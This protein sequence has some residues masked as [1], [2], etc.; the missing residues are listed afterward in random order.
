MT[1]YAAKVCHGCSVAYTP[2]G[3]T[4]K[5]CVPTCRPK[6]IATGCDRKSTVGGGS[7]CAKCSAQ[8]FRDSPEGKEYFQSPYVKEQNYYRWILREFGLTREQYDCMLAAQGFKCA[9]VFCPNTEDLVVDH[10]HTSGVVR[11]ILCRQCNAALG[12]LGDSKSSIM[13]VLEYLSKEGGA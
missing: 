13:L 1:R 3:T 9:L 4:Q 8:N 2:T 11:G 5:Y 6:C 12:K 10:C 7:Y